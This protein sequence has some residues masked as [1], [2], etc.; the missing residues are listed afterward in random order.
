MYPVVHGSLSLAGQMPMHRHVR[1]IAATLQHRTRLN[2][3]LLHI[4]LNCAWPAPSALGDMH[5][6]VEASEVAAIV[7]VAEYDALV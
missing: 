3:R 1:S 6:C 5:G 2:L 7:V 4:E